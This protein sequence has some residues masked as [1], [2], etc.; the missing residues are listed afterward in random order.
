M[1]S[2]G[3]KRREWRRRKLVKR[4]T[5]YKRIDLVEIASSLYKGNPAKLLRDIR[6]LM[7]KGIIGRNRGEINHYYLIEKEPPTKGE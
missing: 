1:K 7:S 4:L 2:K 5:P 3:E 6:I